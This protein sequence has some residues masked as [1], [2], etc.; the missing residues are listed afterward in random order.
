[1]EQVCW[2]PSSPS[3]G[4]G[5][6]GQITV[7]GPGWPAGHLA[8]NQNQNKYVSHQILCFNWT[9]GS[10]RLAVFAYPL[11]TVLESAVVSGTSLGVSSAEVKP[12]EPAK[13]ASSTH[14][15]TSRFIK[16]NLCRPQ[17]VVQQKHI[18]VPALKSTV[19]VNTLNKLKN[20]TAHPHKSAAASG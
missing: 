17:T 8:P 2:R 11:T 4:Q 15:V 14:N 18:F 1:M 9:A 12:P 7:E 3:A 6:E 10:V 16:K 5:R 19:H 13:T 20:T